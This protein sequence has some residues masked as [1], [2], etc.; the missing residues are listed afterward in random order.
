MQDAYY[1]LGSALP[2]TQVPS[3][4]S[5][6]AA[7]QP[8]ISQLAAL[9]NATGKK[10]MITEVG[11]QSRPSCH[12]IPCCTPCHDPT[13]D[14]AWLTDH[15]YTCQAR[16]CSCDFEQAVMIILIR[17][18]QCLRGAAAGLYGAA[19]VCWGLLVAL[20]NGP[21]CRRHRLHRFYCPR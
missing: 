20:E 1:S 8:I 13:D 5:L 10:V 12:E 9:S 4:T 16:N 11:Y 18:G 15:D 7:W 6:V 21:Y 17:A 14:S 19:L 3:I 2:L